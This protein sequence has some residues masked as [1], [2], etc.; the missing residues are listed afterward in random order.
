MNRTNIDYIKM[1]KKRRALTF[2]NS[3]EQE[4]DKDKKVKLFVDMMTYYD[5]VN[6]RDFQLFCM[7]IIND[8]SIRSKDEKL[9]QKI[10]ELEEIKQMESR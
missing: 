4:Q 8:C 3:I 6:A 5:S 2:I 10:K 7:D 1:E 9:I